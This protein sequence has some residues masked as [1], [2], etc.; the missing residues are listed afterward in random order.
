MSRLISLH[1][2]D[3]LKD[4]ETMTYKNVSIKYNISQSTVY[5]INKKYGNNNT[6]IRRINKTNVDD[7]ISSVMK[8]RD[9]ITGELCDNLP[10]VSTTEKRKSKL[11]NKIEEIKNVFKNMDDG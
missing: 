8:N 3:I 11:R 2:D 1:L 10:Q 7:F 6:K 5:N 9:S 4:L